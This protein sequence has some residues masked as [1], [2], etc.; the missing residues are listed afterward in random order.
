MSEKKRWNSIDF[1]KALACTAWY[2]Y[3]SAFP[4]S[5]G[6]PHAE[7]LSRAVPENRAIVDCTRA[8]MV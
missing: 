2:L 8:F 1:A 5:L 3:N 4:M 6:R 7:V